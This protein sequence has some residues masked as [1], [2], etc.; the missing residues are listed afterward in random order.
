MSNKAFETIYPPFE[1]RSF[2]ITDERT[3]M[4]TAVLLYRPSLLQRL[5]VMNAYSHTIT[6]CHSPNLLLIQLDKPRSGF[7]IATSFGL[8]YNPRF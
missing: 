4:H 2:R 6:V 5:R 1:R 3:R 8:D 7:D